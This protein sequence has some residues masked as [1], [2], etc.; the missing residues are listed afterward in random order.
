[1]KLSHIFKVILFLLLPFF[2]LAQYPNN[3]VKSRLGYQT[4]GD[5]LT[6]RGSGVPAFSPGSLANAWMYL[7][8]TN[9]ILYHYK[10]F[11]W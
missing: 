6:F 4:T 8:T 5:G 10:N 9:F 3:P 7:D 2:V 1:M 11:Q